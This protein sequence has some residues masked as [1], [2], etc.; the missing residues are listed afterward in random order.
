[1]T[2]EGTPAGDWPRRKILD[3][4][5]K[6]LRG[7]IAHD[8]SYVAS[9][10]RLCL[11]LCGAR[12]AERSS[13]IQHMS[14]APPAEP[15]GRHPVPVAVVK[16]TDRDRL[17]DSLLLWRGSHRQISVIGPAVSGTP[18]AGASSMGVLIGP[19]LE[20]G[21]RRALVGVTSVYL[22]RG[23]TCDLAIGTL[24]GSSIASAMGGEWLRRSGPCPRSASFG[25][26]PPTA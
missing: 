26:A 14:P 12:C 25:P 6:A 23:M 5:L 24:S 1:M 15:E 13:A 21:T 2:R 16:V 9:R 3:E 11:A 22:P 4:T 20:R 19:L 7:P 10:G 17:T 18:I 8:D